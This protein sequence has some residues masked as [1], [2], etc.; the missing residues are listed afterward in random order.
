MRSILATTLA[1]SLTLVTIGC[2][3]PKDRCPGFRLPGDVVA[4]P[5]DWAATVAPHPL[6]AVEVRTPYLLPHSVTI[7]R[8]IFEGGLVIGA[9]EPDSKNWPGWVDADPNVRL[10]VGDAVYEAKLVPIE[11]A[12]TSRRVLASMRAGTTSAGPPP[13]MKIRFWHVRPRD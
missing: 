9:R 13:E 4:Y 8:G 3:A 10:G 6:I 5:T 7:T 2:L 1:L 12:E 11:D